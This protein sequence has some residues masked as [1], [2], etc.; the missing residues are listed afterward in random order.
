[1]AERFL[2]VSYNY[3]PIA[4]PES[5]LA[6]K[7]VRGLRQLGVEVDVIG[8]APGW[9]QRTDHTLD[10]YAGAVTQRVRT[11][12]WVPAVQPLR[13]TRRYPDAYRFTNRDTRRVLGDLDLRPYDA[14]LT[15]SQWHSVHL[16]GL[17]IK[18]AHPELRWVAHFSDP[19]RNN[20]LRPL[21]G[22]A[23]ALAHREEA[24]VLRA[25]DVLTY[26]T[27]E[28]RSLA[29]EGFVPEAMAK[30]YVVPH[31]HDPDLYPP[32]VV[33]GDG[34]VLR[35][36]GSFYADRTPHGL[37]TG[38][39]IVAQSDPTLLRDV[40][41]ELIGRTPPRMLR[42]LAA[43]GVPAGVVVARPAVDY[44]TSLRLMAE[45]DALLLL[46][47]PA[48]HNVY[49]PSKLV[50]YLGA[51]RPIVGITPPGTARALVVAAGGPVADPSD[52]AAIA[53][54]L[55]A[56]IEA[57]RAT[58]VGR[59]WGVPSVRD[60]HRIDRVAARRLAVMLGTSPPG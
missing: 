43:R 39:A 60:A 22:L 9:W 52:P 24:E 49:L 21:R 13:W 2:V 29:I 37:L 54:A 26:T 4:A 33:A 7:A 51:A 14:I 45:A 56:G 59:P 5:R 16:V 35:H 34:I 38:L 50:D 41:I 11:P 19:W 15:W 3:P 25:A 32:D 12:S 47:A 44:P 57:A 6:T 55:R 30:A 36:V 46:D 10:T 1:M 28:T 48:V 40:R 23:G 8:G 42:E 27:E 53:G 17:G 20:P 58:P 18:R 31:G